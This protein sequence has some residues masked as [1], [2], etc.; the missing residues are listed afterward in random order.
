[1]QLFMTFSDTGLVCPTCAYLSR[2]FKTGKVLPIFPSRKKL[3]AHFYE[4]HCDDKPEFKCDRDGC[5]ESFLSHQTRN[6][7]VKIFHEGMQYPCAICSA[8]YSDPEMLRRHETV[9]VGRKLYKCD[10]CGYEAFSKSSLDRHFGRCIV[11]KPV[12]STSVVG[13]TPP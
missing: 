8:V 2:A 11:G 10:F 13:T 6:R 4:E 3:Q 12:K 9:H 7:H 1:M 5:E